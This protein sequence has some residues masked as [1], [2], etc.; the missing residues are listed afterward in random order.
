MKAPEELRYKSLSLVYLQIFTVEGFDQ[1]RL[2]NRYFKSIPNSIDR[3]I[4]D[5]ASLPRNPVERYRFTPFHFSLR[6]DS[7][8]EGEARTGQRQEPA[9]VEGTMF[10]EM[11][12]FF[13]RTVSITYRAVIDGTR[14]T[15][16]RLLGTDDLIA[17]ASLRVGAEHWNRKREEGTEARTPSNINLKVNDIS[18]ELF[19]LDEEG[20]VL[21]SSRAVPE[22]GCFEEIQRRYKRF[23]LN[24]QR[25]VEAPV[26]AWRRWVKGARRLFP[27]RRRP[28]EAPREEEWRDMNYVHVD[29][30]EDVS[31]ER[32]IFRFMDSPGIIA[33]ILAEHRRELVGLMSFY[34]YE[35]PYRS[36]EA[37]KEVCGEDVAID[38]DDLV[39]LNQ[40]ICVVFG[41]Y[42]LRGAGA[43]TD[44]KEQL[45]E[46]R[47][48][49][50]VS[51][52]EYL[53][54]LE[55]VLAKRYTLDTVA[56]EYLRGTLAISTL[57]RAREQIERNARQVLKVNHTLLQLDAVR[58][59]RF[60]SHK[61]M[62]ERTARALELEEEQR[63]LEEMMEKVDKS[64]CS[65]SETRKLRQSTLLNIVLGSV[66][67]AS[68]LGILLQNV[69][70]PFM[71]AVGWG[72]FADHAGITIVLMTLLIL[73]GSATGIIAY[74]LHGRRGRGA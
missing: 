69:K 66:S 60:I 56:G 62:F 54:I 3:Q 68:L 20:N 67:A 74:R 14:C 45:A 7:S 1:Q 25:P 73:I 43:P 13:A 27:A 55:M 49:Y 64:L 59:S 5:L 35:W 18:V 30:W 47:E 71:V 12:V 40:Y 29:I 17:L 34:P 61:I 72:E 16:S 28:V 57:G 65:I 70:V 9:L 42:G 8:R 58:Y 2:D 4:F 46:A 21:L 6:L 26:P 50:H 63:R 11:S 53:L 22:E 52:P 38:T 51:W 23:V 39:L 10:V 33:H 41:T 15:C 36:P 44:W 48:S 31:H 24:S 37:F 19:H 32:D